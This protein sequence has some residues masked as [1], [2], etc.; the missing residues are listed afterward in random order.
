MRRIFSVLLVL[1]LCAAPAFAWQF[2]TEASGSTSQKVPLYS[3]ANIAA[4]AGPAHKVQVKN[5]GAGT[6]TVS[7][8]YY[9]GTAWTQTHPRAAAASGQAFYAVSDSVVTLAPDEM[10]TVDTTVDY[11]GAHALYITRPTATSYKV[12][13]E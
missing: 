11:Q 4:G 2:I 9:N 13:Y 7:F 3:A 8:H 10:F 6:L 1:L 5:T 12:A